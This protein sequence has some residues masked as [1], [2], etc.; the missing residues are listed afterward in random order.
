MFIGFFQ[1]SER[2]TQRRTLFPLGFCVLSGIK[3]DK[4][5]G[6]QFGQTTKYTNG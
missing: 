3:L 1:M 4:I 5:A 6:I 2:E